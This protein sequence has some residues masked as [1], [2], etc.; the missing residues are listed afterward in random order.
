[1]LIKERFPEAI[2]YGSSG[3]PN[4]NTTV[5]DSQNGRRKKNINWEY[6]LHTYNVAYGVKTMEEM[7]E[8][9]RFFH[10]AEG[11]AHTF[12]YKD[13]ADYNSTIPGQPT[14]SSDQLLGIGDGSTRDFQLVKNYT[15]GS[16]N[17]VR[18][19]ALP[20]Q[21][22]LEVEINGAPTT[23]FTISDTGLITFNV[24]PSAGQ[25]IRAGYEFDVPVSFDD[26]FLPTSYDDYESNS[27]DVTLSEE[28]L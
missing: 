12:L 11:R 8:L 16:H 25:A 23:N 2:S 5:V 18:N 15:V 26:D 24:A 3:G 17:K 14:S 20:V 7:H 6:P 10:I 1:M 13:W 19:I 27:A 28:R 22:T 21:G 4:Y 9:L